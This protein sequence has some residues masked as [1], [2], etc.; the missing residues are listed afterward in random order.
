S[1]RPMCFQVSP[2]SADLYTPSPHD[3][4]W[5]L[6]ASPVPTQT[7]F[8]SEGAIA[9][10][11]IDKAV[12]SRSNTGVHV[13]PLLTLLNTPPDPVPTKMIDAFPGSASTSSMRPPKEAGPIWRHAM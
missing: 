12:P 5:R 11:P 3:E 10:S 8:G 1:S 7:R 9:M 13:T 6:F 2:P 4:L